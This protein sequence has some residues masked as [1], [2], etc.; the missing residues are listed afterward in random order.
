MQICIWFFNIFNDKC[1]SV[2]YFYYFI[3]NTNFTFYNIDNIRRQTNEVTYRSAKATS[4]IASSQIMI[5]ISYC[6][7]HLLINDML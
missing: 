5:D 3:H 6:I 7:E 1:D 4:Y 2:L